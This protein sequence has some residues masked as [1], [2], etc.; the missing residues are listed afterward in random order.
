MI[1]DAPLI[2][3]FLAVQWYEYVIYSSADG[4]SDS[5]NKTV[6]GVGGASA[7]A[8]AAA[9]SAGGSGGGGGSSKMTATFIATVISL[10]STL[11]RGSPTITQVRI[12]LI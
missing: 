4:S 12:L 8:T 9:G 3:F 2:I 7:V 5:E 1:Q 10:L 6:G 11:C